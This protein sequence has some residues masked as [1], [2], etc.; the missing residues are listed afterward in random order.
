MRASAL[1]CLA[2]IARLRKTSK[3]SGRRYGWLAWLG[4]LY[5][6][7]SRASRRPPS[8]ESTSQERPEESSA[9]GTERSM[10]RRQL[11]VSGLP[12]CQVCGARIPVQGRGHG[13]LRPAVLRPRPAPRGERGS[14]G[15]RARGRCR[16]SGSSSLAI[17]DVR[18]PRTELYDRCADVGRRRI[19]GPAAQAPRGVGAAPRRC[20]SRGTGC[21]S[22]SP[23]V[24]RRLTR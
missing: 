2:G 9:A 22:G 1:A 18:S 5:G 13:V 10:S 23:W 20:R 14:S 4:S 3:P 12:S 19:G 24:R 21:W 7:P 6:D 16:S 8:R 17:S 11:S 15:S